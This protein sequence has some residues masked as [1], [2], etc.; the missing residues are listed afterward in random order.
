MAM[1]RGDAEA[2]D[3]AVTALERVVVRMEVESPQQV[4]LYQEFVNRL[5]ELEQTRQER[6]SAAGS[7]LPVQARCCSGT[8]W[9]RRH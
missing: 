8:N 6:L 5:S 7:R 2:V 1:L 3:D 9:G 4:A